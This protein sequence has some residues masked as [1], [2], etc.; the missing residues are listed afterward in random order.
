MEFLKNAEANGLGLL[1]LWALL[2]VLLMVC[3]SSMVV[4]IATST[5]IMLSD[6]EMVG[7][8]TSEM[9]MSDGLAGSVTASMVP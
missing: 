5:K 3:K 6:F 1:I 2:V 8:D 9:V 4:C 7:L